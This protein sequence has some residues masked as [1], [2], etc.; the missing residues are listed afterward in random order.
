MGSV[1]KHRKMCSFGGNTLWVLNSLERNALSCLKYDFWNSF[2]AKT[3]NHVFS[4]NNAS[5]SPLFVA[6]G[7]GADDDGFVVIAVVMFS[8]PSPS[9]S[10]PSLSFFSFF[11]EVKN[12]VR[13]FCVCST[14]RLFVFIRTTIYTL[15][16]LFVLARLFVCGRFLWSACVWGVNSFFFLFQKS[17]LKS[18]CSESN[19]LST[20]V[21][22]CLY[23]CIYPTKSN[24]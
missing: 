11:E 23:T 9:S 18:T 15:L 17:S 3:S 12:D 22:L 1:L 13:D 20:T 10:T 2:S 6:T 19:L 5:N 4:V 16:L 14:L 7:G 24:S 21:Q 8:F